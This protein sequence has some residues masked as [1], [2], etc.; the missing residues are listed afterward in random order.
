MAKARTQRKTKSRAGSKTKPLKKTRTKSARK[1][2]RRPVRKPAVRANKRTAVKAPHTKVYPVPAVLA[3]RAYID[4]K[5]FR[6]MYKR[7]VKNPDGFWA[8]QAKQF[9]TW[10]KPWSKV[11]DWSF[12][13][14]N[15]HIK[16]FIDGKLNVS[17]NCLDRHLAKRGKQVAMIWEGDD[18][19]DDRQI[20]YRELH[21]EVC[22]FANVL[23]ARGV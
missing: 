10:S 21:A 13:A 8:E 11:S 17:W 22:Q 23:K 12:D 1:A 15:L 7:S 6:A 18:P 20:T 9:V 14:K 16:W 3:K 4:A 2:V 19:K 5:K